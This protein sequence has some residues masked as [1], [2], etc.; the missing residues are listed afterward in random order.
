MTEPQRKA[1]MLVKQL[2]DTDPDP[3]VRDELCRMII[4]RR[5]Q[6]AAEHD[7]GAEA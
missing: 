2:A 7:A 4:R 6:H 5:R 3:E 1:M